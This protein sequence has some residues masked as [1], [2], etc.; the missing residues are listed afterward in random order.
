MI[1]KSTSAVTN[2]LQI[3]EKIRAR[4]VSTRRRRLDRI[5]VGRGELGTDCIPVV[6]PSPT[7]S[8]PVI[9]SLSKGILSLSK[10]I[11][12]LSKVTLSLSKGTLAR[13]RGPRVRARGASG[14]RAAPTSTEAVPPR[15]QRLLGLAV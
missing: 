6:L 13:R 3:V 14:C 12:S 7:R 9:L 1:T 10:G 15:L 8:P 4:S 2:G 5:G 11:L